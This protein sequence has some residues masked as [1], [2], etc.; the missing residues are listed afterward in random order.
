MKYGSEDIDLGVNQYEI[1]VE[2]FRDVE[3]RQ[4]GWA[5]WKCEVQ[6]G[7]LVEANIQGRA[8]ELHGRQ[9]NIE[10]ELRS[11]NVSIGN[12]KKSTWGLAGLGQ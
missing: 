4:R 3:T 5:M 11:G 6:D 12:F 10:W 8:E 7:T 1:I 2:A 9:W